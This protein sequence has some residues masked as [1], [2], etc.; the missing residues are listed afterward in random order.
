MPRRAILRAL[1]PTRSMSEMVFMTE[2]I[3]RRSIAVGWRLA[4]TW[5]HSASIPT[6]SSLTRSSSRM[7]FSSSG[8]SPLYSPSTALRTCSSASPPI[9]STRVRRLSSSRS[10]FLDV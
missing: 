5:L 2:T 4:I 6:S 10:K 7:T 8:M 1:S 9:C 3:M